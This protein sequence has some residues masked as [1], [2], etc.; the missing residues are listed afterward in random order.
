MPPPEP[1]ADA[2]VSPSCRRPVSDRM[3][4][5]PK[6]PASMPKHPG[7]R[8]GLGGLRQPHPCLL[9]TP[10]ADLAATAATRRA[11]MP[12]AYP[13]RVR[14]PLV[15][16][17]R[18]PAAGIHQRQIGCRDLPRRGEPT[19][20]AVHRHVTLVHGSQS[21]ELTA[22]P[23]VEVVKWHGVLC[24]EVTAR[25]APRLCSVGPPAFGVMSNLKI[26]VGR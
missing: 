16:G 4:H 15:D 26:S 10:L 11:A 7:T 19:L 22:Q 13:R 17:K 23:T 12:A 18:F 14:G 1:I 21:R 5:T 3:V 9:G 6:Y 8:T 24:Y 20:R 25:S 2:P